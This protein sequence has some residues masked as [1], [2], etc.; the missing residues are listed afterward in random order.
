MQQS[1]T[2]NFDEDLKGQNADRDV[3][4]NGDDDEIS[5][6]NADSME[7]RLQGPCKYMG[8]AFRPSFVKAWA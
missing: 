8:P 3:D 1:L 5:G 6:G 2:G 7:T 4:S